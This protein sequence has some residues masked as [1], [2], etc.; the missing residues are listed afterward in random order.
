MRICDISPLPDANKVFERFCLVTC[1]S[2]VLLVLAQLDPKGF[3][4]WEFHRNS[5]NSSWFWEAIAQMPLDI[6]EQLPKGTYG[7]RCQGMG[8]CIGF[9]SLSPTIAT[10]CVYY[11]DS[12]LWKWLPSCELDVDNPYGNKCMAFQPRPDL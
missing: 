2:W 6:I 7:I 12:K 3:V 10:V 11:L 9:I 4:I 8:D 1:G 5:S